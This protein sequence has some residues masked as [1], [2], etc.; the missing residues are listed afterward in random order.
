MAKNTKRLIRAACIAV[1]D[2]KTAEP[3]EVIKAAT[4]LYKME[5]RRVKGKP[6]G[7]PFPKKNSQGSAVDRISELTG[8]LQ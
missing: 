7:K 3:A 4:L 1:L 6:R 8:A 5:L 2:G